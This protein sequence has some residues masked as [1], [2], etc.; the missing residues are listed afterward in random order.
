MFDFK[1]LCWLGIVLFFL[2][3]R[4]FDRTRKKAMYILSLAWRNQ[5][6]TKPLFYE[7]VTGR[8]QVSTSDWFPN[9]P[10]AEYF[11]AINALHIVNSPIR[12]VREREWENMGNGGDW[13]EQ[14]LWNLSQR[15]LIRAFRCSSQITSNVFKSDISL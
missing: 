11:E 2:Q 1:G 4:K 6:W 14:T 3:W 10:A 9:K 13:K 5:S 8:L 15:K 12:F 7:Y